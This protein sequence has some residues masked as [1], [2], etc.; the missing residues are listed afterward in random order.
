MPRTEESKPEP[1]AEESSE[2]YYNAKSILRE[3]KVQGNIQYLVDWEGL[4]PDTGRPYDPTWVSP[5]RRFVAPLHISQEF[6]ISKT[7][8]RSQQT[9]LLRI[10]SRSGKGKKAQS[11][12]RTSASVTEPSPVWYCLSIHQSEWPTDH[13]RS[14][15][16][17]AEIRHLN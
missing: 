3:R 14:S 12:T 11:A 9:T 16:K 1:I 17:V 13:E 6:T 7:Y 4:D 5:E 10:L 2:T 8:L 15:N